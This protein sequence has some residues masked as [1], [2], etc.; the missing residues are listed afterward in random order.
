[1]VTAAAN[2]AVLTFNP[3]PPTPNHRPPTSYL[4]PPTPHPLMASHSVGC[5][6]YEL[7]ML[8]SPFKS[9]GLNLYSL[10]QK[11]SKADFQPLPEHYSEDLRNLAYSMIN[12]DPQQVR[13]G[14]GWGGRA[15]AVDLDPLTW[16]RIP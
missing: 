5:L 12:I 16:I 9:E 1:M 7:A 10:F 13:W 11:I 14:W 2:T 8:K 6:L 3:R 15:Q 4:Q